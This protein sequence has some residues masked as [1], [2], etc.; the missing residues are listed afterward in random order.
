MDKKFQR[1][2]LKKDFVNH[3][4]IFLP[5]EIAALGLVAGR[6][7]A[8]LPSAGNPFCFGIATR[9]LT[10]LEGEPQLELTWQHVELAN[11]PSGQPEFYRERCRLALQMAAQ[12]MT[13]LAGL[14]NVQDL[15]DPHENA[16]KDGVVFHSDRMAFASVNEGE[17][18][19]LLG[20]EFGC[21][22]TLRDNAFA[23]AFLTGMVETILAMDRE[24]E[25]LRAAN[26]A[27]WKM[28]Q[29]W[30]IA[31]PSEQV[32]NWLEESKFASFAR[33]RY[34]HSGPRNFFG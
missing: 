10:S 21:L 18:W 9:R 1:P 28:C 25:N 7:S 4:N 22:Q 14:S 8:T 6:L 3:A 34:I 12:P 2:L 24:N 5:E 31:A 17:G 16:L 11:P 27:F 20:L 15:C 23:V 30:S 29:G 33:E 26:T 32:R 19:F 13:Y